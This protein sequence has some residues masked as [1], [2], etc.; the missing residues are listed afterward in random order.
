MTCYE[1]YEVVAPAGVDGVYQGA[2]GVAVSS[3]VQGVHST[4]DG[5]SHG[6]QVSTRVGKHSNT[7]V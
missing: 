5:G 3:G 6:D 7:L 4:H 2:Y 1:D